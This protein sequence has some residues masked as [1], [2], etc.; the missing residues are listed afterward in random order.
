M[1]R[2]L[3]IP[4]RVRH[5]S[6]S[7]HKACDA[8]PLVR[9][10]AALSAEHKNEEPRPL[11]FSGRGS[12]TSAADA[13]I[14]DSDEDVSA[15]S[16]HSC[17]VVPGAPPVN[18]GTS[19]DVIDYSDED[20]ELPP[21]PHSENKAENKQPSSRFPLTRELPYLEDVSEPMP[22]NAP[23]NHITGAG[24]AVALSGLHSDDASATTSDSEADGT[25]EVVSVA[26]D[27]NGSKISTLHQKLPLPSSQ[28]T[29]DSL[30]ERRWRGHPHRDVQLEGTIVAPQASQQQ[31]EKVFPKEVPT[32]S[33]ST[34]EETDFQVSDPQ[35]KRVPLPKTAH[36][37]ARRLL[38]PDSTDLPLIAIT[39]RGD[40]HF[41]ERKKK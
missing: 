7:A 30:G 29:R 36:G 10:T 3:S 21:S 15:V 11:V 35:L 20:I 39:M 27:V 38:K 41:I 17:T 19:R 31:G 1:R 16:S 12:G 14:I 2:C 6:G 34:N 32:Y 18:R 22:S 13:I 37:R 9:Q 33:S 5:K 4:N 40:C 28:P 23:R 24:T 8:T 26:K 25:D